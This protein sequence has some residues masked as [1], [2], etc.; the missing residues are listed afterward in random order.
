MN[1]CG[2]LCRDDEFD[3]DLEDIMVMEA[4]WQS[5]QVC[6]FASGCHLGT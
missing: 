1:I 6:I 4:I 3:F 5:I 2:D